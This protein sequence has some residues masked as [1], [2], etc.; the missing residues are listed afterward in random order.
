MV[1]IIELSFDHDPKFEKV[2]RNLLS[3]KVVLHVSQKLHLY[4]LIADFFSL[5]AVVILLSKAQKTLFD[6]LIYPLKSTLFIMAES[7]PS[8]SLKSVTYSR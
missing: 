3:T 6:S 2:T 8:F 1:K 5:S 7:K 4:L